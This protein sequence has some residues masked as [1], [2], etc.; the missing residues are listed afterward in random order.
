MRKLTESDPSQQSETFHLAKAD[1]QYKWLV[2]GDD[3]WGTAFSNSMSLEVQSP[4]R[5][6]LFL[7]FP[8][9]HALKP[10]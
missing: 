8:L 2:T 9:K 7:Y 1:E 3:D 4:T 5:W 6:P 10:C